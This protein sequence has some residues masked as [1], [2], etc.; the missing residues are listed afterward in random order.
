M[1]RHLELGLRGTS[2]ALVL[3]ELSVKAALDSHVLSVAQQR[4]DLKG[5]KN[6]PNTQR[7]VG[8][9]VQRLLRDTEEINYN[10]VIVPVYHLSSW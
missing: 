1:Q 8:I 7:L 6:K 3:I 2:Q 4:I 5:K 9:K 10:F